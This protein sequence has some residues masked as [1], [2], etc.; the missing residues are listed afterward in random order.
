MFF[1]CQETFQVRDILSPVLN[2]ATISFSL[3]KTVVNGF[4][5]GMHF[6]TRFYASGQRNKPTCRKSRQSN[7]SL[8]DSTIVEST[9]TDSEL[10]STGTATSHPSSIA[11]NLKS[12]HVI[13]RKRTVLPII[14]YRDNG[15]RTEERNSDVVP[16]IRC[17]ES[18][19]DTRRLGS[20]PV[21]LI[22]TLILDVKQDPTS[23]VCHSNCL[24]SHGITDQL[25]DSSSMGNKTHIL[26]MNRFLEIQK[27]EGLTPIERYQDR[28]HDVCVRQ[29]SK[30]DLL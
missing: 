30:Q 7:P 6:T 28:Q 15:D 17:V 8:V 20:N 29:P 10:L 2:N 19:S 4:E 24:G 26:L 22:H 25:F 13:R 5:H 23:V 1:V 18:R 16:H 11:T 27:N 21:L 9:T 14:Q 12:G 3:F